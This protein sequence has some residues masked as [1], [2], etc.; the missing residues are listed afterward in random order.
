[1]DNCVH[2]QGSTPAPFGG[3]VAPPLRDLACG[4]GGGQTA[5]FVV[6]DTVLGSATITAT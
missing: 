2:T 6:E 3:S 4:V 5:G 1:L